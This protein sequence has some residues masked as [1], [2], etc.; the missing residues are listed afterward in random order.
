M[1]KPQKKRV[2]HWE[3]EVPSSPS[4]R[5]DNIDHF[6]ARGKRWVYGRGDHFGK[7]TVNM[8]VWLAKDGRLFARFWSRNDE[9]DWYS[10]EIVGLSFPKRG[11]NRA[12]EEFGEHWVPDCLRQEYDNWVLS[13]V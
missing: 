6:D 13:E 1:S 11:K 12:V 5:V 2:V 10:Y 9:V 7:L 4:I 3:D 8:D